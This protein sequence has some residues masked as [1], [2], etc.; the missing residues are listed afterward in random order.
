M[1]QVIKLD[2][3]DTVS[4]EFNKIMHSDDICFGFD[5]EVTQFNGTSKLSTIQIAISETKVI[6]LHFSYVDLK[7]EFLDEVIMN[8][9]L[10][11]FLT[12]RSKIKVG[13]GLTDDVRKINSA[14][15]IEMLGAVDVQFLALSKGLTA[16]SMDDLGRS[17]I[18]NYKPKER[19]NGGYNV[20]SPAHIKYI[21]QDAIN[22]LLIYQKLLEWQPVPRS[23]SQ[24][25]TKE[26][27]LFL[28]NYIRQSPGHS[29]KLLSA[30]NYMYNSLGV[31]RK[32]KTLSEA[33]STL[34]KI[35]YALAQCDIHKRSEYGLENVT[36][37]DDSITVKFL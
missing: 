12:S 18:T 8:S 16:I 9:S 7:C 22:S 13:I 32:T 2:T 4:R 27:V 3:Y 30:G 24:I 6:Y 28:L 34:R 31:W 23:N 35:T 5:I 10:I 14:F 37:I 26:E 21:S 33:R 1:E 11:M 19:V 20:L 17:L 36:L 15:G 29:V 25:V